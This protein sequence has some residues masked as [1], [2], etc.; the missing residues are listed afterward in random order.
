MICF[1]QCGTTEIRFKVLA[2]II[3]LVTN[4]RD[5]VNLLT[6]IL[7][8]CSC[9]VSSGP[10]TDFTYLK[11]QSPEIS[12]QNV[13]KNPIPTP[14]YLCRIQ[15]SIVGLES[16]DIIP[17]F[18]KPGLYG[19]KTVKGQD[20]GVIAKNILQQT[21]SKRRGAVEQSRSIDFLNG[22]SMSLWPS[23]LSG[24]GSLI[25]KSEWT[26]WNVLGWF[27]MLKGFAVAGSVWSRKIKSQYN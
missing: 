16:Q 4:F 21:L 15:G 17:L 18:S 27:M 13:S 22:C 5:G 10:L 7:R 25:S 19:H 11:R 1:W 20:L 2:A 3:M 26:K 23:R 12:N 6:T 24:N 14:Y 8:R 9:H